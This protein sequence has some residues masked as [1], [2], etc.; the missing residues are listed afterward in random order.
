MRL[1]ALLSLL[2][3]RVANV[4]L[5]GRYVRVS[6]LAAGDREVLLRGWAF[7]RLPL[8]RTGFQALK[9][10]CQFAHFCGVNPMLAI[11]ALPDHVARGINEGWRSG[12]C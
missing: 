7:S 9:R 11:M 10:L 4:V 2:D 12:P 1:G 5:S 8:K 3:S 6:E